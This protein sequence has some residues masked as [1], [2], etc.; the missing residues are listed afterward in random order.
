MMNKTFALLIALLMLI[1]PLVTGG[2]GAHTLHDVGHEHSVDTMPTLYAVPLK[3]GERLRVVATTSIVADVVRQVGGDQIEL[4]TLMP[5]GTDPH[6]FEPSPLDAAAIADAHVVF[7][8]GAGLEIFLEKFFENA[9]KEVPV[10]PVSYGLEMLELEEESKHD[11]HNDHHHQG[12]VD[13]HVWFDPNNVMAWVDNIEHAL[14]ALDPGN[15]R[16]YRANA[17]KY[18]AELVALDSWIRDMVARVA[19]EDR[20]L[21][22][23]HAAL[24]YFAHRYGFEQSGA[25]FPG[26]STLTEPSARELAV[27]EENIREQGIKAIFVSTTVNPALAERIATDTGARLVFLYTGS[28]SEPDGPADSYIAFMRYNVNAIVAALCC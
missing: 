12:G 28:L 27:L 21:V 19:K 15:S 4:T 16:V 25:V 20:K 17:E 2:C 6:A 26:F 13:P 18:K 7:A 24:G 5:V 3:A 9:G 10:V 23:D 8:N 11:G 1:L 14:S 22:V